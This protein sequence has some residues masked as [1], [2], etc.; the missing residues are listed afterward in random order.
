MNQYKNFTVEQLADDAK[1]RKWILNPDETTVRF[2]NNWLEDNPEEVEKIE[3]AKKLVRLSNFQ[4]SNMSFNKADALWE[5]IE[6]KMDTP[7]KETKVV[8][9]PQKP[10][11]YLFK[12]AAAI[13]LLIVA[14]YYFYNNQLPSK[15]E[16]TEIKYVTKCNPAGRN[17]SIK[18]TD[19]TIINLNAE[20]K[21]KFPE[22]F[23]GDE[24]R[25][26]L[27]GEAFFEVSK[28]TSKPFIVVTNQ[29]ETK[30]L[31][32]S[33]NIQ[34][35]ATDNKVQI[36]LVEG[37]VQVNSEA[38]SKSEI[39]APSEM[40]EIKRNKVGE[41][42]VDRSHFDAKE[43]LSWKD[44]IL[45][46]NDASFEEIIKRLGRWYGVKFNTELNKQIN[47]GYT[48]QY[49][50]ASLGEVLD[51]LGFTLGFNYEIQDKNVKIFN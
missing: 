16:K 48:G 45:F 43:I 28:D 41:M 13:L 7:R 42:L 44:G 4:S 12:I 50:N 3:A 23:T 31:G 22:R 27:E 37:S 11:R 17:S 25:V 21:L 39:L 19:G 14:G 35:Y 47:R 46:F 34:S 38:F 40:L 5:E 1:F 20:S 8:Y 26:F 29:I 36:A 18:L 51:G 30:V 10:N 32:T 2:W 9:E 6:A 33:F 15:S 24:R 49:N